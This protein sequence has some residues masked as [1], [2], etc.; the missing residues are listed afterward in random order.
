MRQKEPID[1]TVVHFMCLSTKLCWNSGYVSHMFL[2]QSS[3]IYYI[4]KHEWIAKTHASTAESITAWSLVYIIIHE[5]IIYF[6]ICSYLSDNILSGGQMEP[7]QP[8]KIIQKRSQRFSNVGPP[9]LQFSI[10][11]TSIIYSVDDSADA[12]CLGDTPIWK[13][14]MTNW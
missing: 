13:V 7:W 5:G 12:R 14:R 6:E 11:L 2:L 8:V 1:V 4:I 10:K 3:K 9:H